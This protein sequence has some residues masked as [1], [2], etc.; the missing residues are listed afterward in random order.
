MQTFVHCYL[1]RNVVYVPAVVKLK[2]G[3]Y[4]D[5]EPVEVCPIA[6]MDCIRRALA[7]ALAKGNIV[8]P[9]PPKDNWPPPVVLKYA[10][11]KTWSAFARGTSPWSL[12]VEDGSYR[13][14]GS[15]DHP[16]G[17]W[18]KDP[19]RTFELPTGSGAEDAITRM[20][21]ILQDEARKKADH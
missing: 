21:E 8:V 2:T 6:N 13:I 18:V 12:E 15:R 3:A 14:V 17:Y 10:G 11:A 4:W 20:I 5:V 1:R 7:S 16:D 9:P 19:K